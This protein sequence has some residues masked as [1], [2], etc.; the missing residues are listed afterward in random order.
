VL[1]SS[2]SVMGSSGELCIVHVFIIGEYIVGSGVL[3]ESV[4]LQAYFHAPHVH[5]HSCLQV[6]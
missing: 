4:F 1:Y 2:D 3:I 6:S 5:K